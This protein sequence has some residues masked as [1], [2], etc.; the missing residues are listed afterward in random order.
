MRYLWFG[1][2]MGKVEL[3]DNLRSVNIFNQQYNYIWARRLKL[4]FHGK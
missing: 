4:K 1:T 2:N 3:Q